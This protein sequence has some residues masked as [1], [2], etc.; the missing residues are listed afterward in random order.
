ML[1]DVVT[2]GTLR[3]RTS[4]L[5]AFCERIGLVRENCPDAE[6]SEH[7][8]FVKD[9]KDRRPRESRK[10]GTMLYQWRTLVPAY[11]ERLTPIRGV[12]VRII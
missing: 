5:R 7:V 9:R 1:M 12:T 8:A 10:C 3:D 11:E 2:L 4:N 6:S